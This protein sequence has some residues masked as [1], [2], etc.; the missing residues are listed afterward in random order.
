MQWLNTVL[1]HEAG[2]ILYSQ[3][4]LSLTHVIRIEGSVKSVLRMGCMKRAELHYRDS[5]W[6]QNAKLDL[7]QRDPADAVKDAEALV[8]FAQR[9]LDDLQKPEMNV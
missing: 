8:G 1:D 6:L 7:L 5:F 2:T 9:R 4:V 3:T